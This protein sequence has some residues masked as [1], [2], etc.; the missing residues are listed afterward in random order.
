MEKF[1]YCI[2]V[3]IIDFGCYQAFF[4]LLSL[5]SSSRCDL[6]IALKMKFYWAFICHYRMCCKLNNWLHIN[7][8]KSMLIYL[9]YY[10]LPT[11]R[12][13]LWIYLH[14]LQHLLLNGFPPQLLSH[15]RIDHD[16]CCKSDL[17]VKWSV[18]T[19]F[20]FF[21]AQIYIEVLFQFIYFCD[22]LETPL[23]FN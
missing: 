18:D 14:C 7:V 13:H 16:D 23:D 3:C 22:F 17:S 12:S 5:I 9:K 15:F 8:Q 19:I 10:Y 4:R 11:F 2:I 21:N 1:L 6:Y 20:F